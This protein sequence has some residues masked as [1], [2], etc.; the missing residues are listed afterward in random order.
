MRSKWFWIVVACVGAAGAWWYLRHRP[1]EQAPALQEVRVERGTLRR[2]VLATGVVEPQ[3]RVEI[4][5]P[6]A[7]RIEDVLVREGETVRKGQ[8]LAWMSSSER[9]AL[10]DAARA[11]GEAELAHWEELYRAAPLL[12]P[13]DG[14]II[15]RKVEPGQTVTAADAV[16]VL[17]DRLI[18]QAQ[19][20]ET[21]IGL[22]QLGQ[23]AEIDVDA[24]TGKTVPAR[25]DHIAYEATTVNNVT[26]YEVDVL[27]DQV[28]EFMRSGMTAN[29]TLLV[30][31]RENVLVLP[32]EAVRR[33]NGGATVQMA[34]PGGGPAAAVP[35]TC[36]LE[37]GKKIEIVS[38]VSEGDTVLVRAFSLPPAAQKLTNPFAPMPPGGGRRR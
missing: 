37:D 28:P 31:L 36:G 14:T 1:A 2:T 8:I 3:N 18:V 26:I 13:L 11:K 27:P 19:V 35:V 20:D 9:A 23:R 30:A 12:A 15:A 22:V 38:G 17:A 5:P 10:L 21:D 16:L 34:G 4:K 7:G 25:V 24:Y 32:S 6:I 33:E 29:V